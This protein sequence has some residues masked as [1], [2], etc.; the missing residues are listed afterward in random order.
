MA[1][2]SVS[3]TA[4]IRPSTSEDTAALLSISE[5]TKMFKP[6]ELIALREV[7]D[8]Y[9]Q[10]NQAAG[11]LC[12]TLESRGQI[13]GFTCFAEAAMTDRTWY[14]YWIAVNPAAQGQGLGSQLL[15]WTETVIQQKYGRQLLI[16]TGSV[17]HYEP[18]RRFYLNHRYEQVAVVPDY[19]A[20]GDSMVVFRKRFV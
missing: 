9:H 11:H 15:Q 12:F 14:L 20:E 18:T 10:I 1:E 6:I 17:P 7:L 13:T 8:D 4:F 19:Y 5:A 16:E 3:T 2:H